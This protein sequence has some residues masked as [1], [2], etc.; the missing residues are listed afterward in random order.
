M[1]R[2]SGGTTAAT[3]AVKAAPAELE[4]DKAADGAAA[5]E[6]GGRHGFSA[7]KGAPKQPPWANH[8]AAGAAE[9]SALSAAAAAAGP[10]E[11]RKHG[12]AELRVHKAWASLAHEHVA[13][14][15]RLAACR[16]EPACCPTEFARGGLLKLLQ[17][18]GRLAVTARGGINEYLSPKRKAELTA[19]VQ[20]HLRE[21]ADPHHYSASPNTRLNY[22]GNG[23]GQQLWWCGEGKKGGWRVTQPNR[24]LLRYIAELPGPG[25]L[26]QAGGT[27]GRERDT[28][29]SSDDTDG[30]S[31]SSDDAGG[32]SPGGAAGG[33]RQRLPHDDEDEALSLAPPPMEILEDDIHLLPM[34]A[35]HDDDVH[36]PP[37]PLL[38]PLQ[39]AAAQPA[40]AVE[41]EQE[42]Q[43]EQEQESGATHDRIMQGFTL[44]LDMGTNRDSEVADQSAARGCDNLPP[45]PA[46]AQPAL[47]RKMV[48]VAVAQ[49][50]RLPL[51]AIRDLL[52]GR[53]RW[54]PQET[55]KTRQPP[56]LPA[57]RPTVVAK[58]PP[59]CC[60]D[61]GAL[62]P[63][64]KP[65]AGPTAKPPCTE[66][67]VPSRANQRPTHTTAADDGP[68]WRSRVAVSEGWVRVALGRGDTLQK[69]A[70]I[71][72]LDV[73]AIKAANGI[74]HTGLEVWRDEVWLPLGGALVAEEWEDEEESELV[75]PAGL[76]HVLRLGTAAPAS[77]A[78]RLRG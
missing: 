52:T 77:A 31:G 19:A 15:W 56:D 35:S 25:E 20:A 46:A 45:A 53:D 59:R 76:S 39:E 13:L 66:G 6:P 34:C 44:D 65:Q 48:H 36:D 70:L 54:S 10:A 58:E 67:P 78:P 47:A 32:T 63:P 21:T 40:P 61:E 38:E 43:E 14:A 1:E 11:V 26:Q 71:H 2:S 62:P 51:Q 42:Q 17:S 29:T 16:A 27:G 33:K 4:S 9:V 18:E 41:E 64:L 75:Y 74:F 30:S 7:A 55:G 69:L 57:E 23:A 24:L 12:P 3:V 72:G 68:E 8:P 37:P 5:G 73:S 22:G 28:N 50:R 49:L 60:V